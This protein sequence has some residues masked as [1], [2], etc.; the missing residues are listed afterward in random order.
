MITPRWDYS[1]EI[2]L[3]ISS[4]IR[5]LLDLLEFY[6]SGDSLYHT[7]IWEELLL[8]EICHL[9]IGL[10]WFLPEDSHEWCVLRREDLEYPSMTRLPVH[11]WLCTMVEGDDIVLRGHAHWYHI[12]HD[13]HI[14]SQIF[15][16]TYLRIRSCS[17]LSEKRVDRIW[18]EIPGFSHRIRG[19]YG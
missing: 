10:S 13:I 9:I 17:I 3:M 6:I 8:R 16:N 4:T 15:E 5:K 7:I 18:G 12:R 2:E 14:I 1:T 11:E 19:F